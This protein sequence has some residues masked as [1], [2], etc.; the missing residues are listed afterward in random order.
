MSLLTFCVCHVDNFFPVFLFFG[1]IF[2]IIIYSSFSLLFL[3]RNRF[4]WSYHNCS[5]G[6]SSFLSFTA[7]P[8]LRVFSKNNFLISLQPYTHLFLTEY[9]PLKASLI[10]LKKSLECFRQW[11]LSESAYHN[12]EKLQR[13]T[14]FIYLN[15]NCKKYHI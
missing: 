12:N 5:K 14:H 8:W 4:I 15:L 10:S 2:F 11:A 7:I 3:K 13:I 1:N 9:Y 6:N